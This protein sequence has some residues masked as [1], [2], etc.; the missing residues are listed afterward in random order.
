MI[1][2][3]AEEVFF[4]WLRVKERGAHVV[5]GDRADPYQLE[6]VLSATCTKKGSQF[7]KHVDKGQAVTQGS[8]RPCTPSAPAL[9]VHVSKVR[10]LRDETVLEV[11]SQAACT[12]HESTDTRRLARILL[13]GQLAQCCQGAWARVLFADHS[14]CLWSE[15]HVSGDRYV[16]ALSLEMGTAS[17]ES[18][19][20]QPE[21]DFTLSAPA[22]KRLRR[23]HTAAPQTRTHALRLS[24]VHSSFRF[25]IHP[26]IHQ[27]NRS[28]VCRGTA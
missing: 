13:C 1:F 19:D 28:C 9:G 21:N 15:V 25:S 12:R 17:L 24:F 27:F 23:T 5:A 3:R 11:P 20:W 4:F 16:I 26:H 7:W 18:H 2:G 14:V 8:R 6:E 22:T 10:C